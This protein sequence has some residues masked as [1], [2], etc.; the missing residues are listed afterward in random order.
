MKMKGMDRITPG[1]LAERIASLRRASKSGIVSFYAPDGPDRNSDFFWQGHS[2]LVYIH[3]LDTLVFNEPDCK[4]YCSYDGGKAWEPYIERLLGESDGMETPVENTGWT[5]D[6]YL[7]AVYCDLVWSMAHD[8]FECPDLDSEDHVERYAACNPVT[9][10]NMEGYNAFRLCGA[11]SLASDILAFFS[12][13]NSGKQLCVAG[14]DGVIS[15]FSLE[16]DG[17]ARDYSD[18]DTVYRLSLVENGTYAD[19][20]GESVPVQTFST[21]LRATGPGTF[22]AKARAFIFLN[23]IL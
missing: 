9:I 5:H 10:G 21:L 4:S 3:E 1:T 22:Y 6:G 2:S 11:G 17:D 18:Y 7:E 20:D 13:I 16:K 14:K 19:V 23:F 15:R 8:D 12:L